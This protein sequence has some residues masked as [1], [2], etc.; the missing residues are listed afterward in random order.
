MDLHGT[1]TSFVHKEYKCIQ[2]PEHLHGQWFGIYYQVTKFICALKVQL[3]DKN[4]PSSYNLP[5][6]KM[7]F[8]TV[9]RSVEQIS[10]QKI[11][12]QLVLHSV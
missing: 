10:L 7:V 11:G 9:L 2:E 4:N 6:L 8:Y 1:Y 5:P 12:Q 3:T